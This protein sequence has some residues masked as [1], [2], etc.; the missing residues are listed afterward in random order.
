M[1]V[2]KINELIDFIRGGTYRFNM[3]EYDCCIAGQL[4]VLRLKAKGG[5][6]DESMI[7]Y[8]SSNEK[9]AA[10]LDITL[11]QAEELCLSTPGAL[12]SEIDREVAAKTL[13]R[14][15]DTGVVDFKFETQE[16]S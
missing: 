4:A 2:Q 16:A 7:L 8:E 14:L 9:V 11:D 15:R 13:E 3:N 10:D 12:Y 1:N 6:V 5:K